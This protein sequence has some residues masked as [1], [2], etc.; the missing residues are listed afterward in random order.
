MP[1]KHQLA[2]LKNKPNKF[3][4]NRVKALGGGP[5]ARALVLRI[6]I[7]SPRKP[8]SAKR[9]AAKVIS[10]KTKKAVFAHVPGLGD[11]GVNK[12]AI[13]M[14]EG[15]GFKDVGGVN[16]SMIRG[17]LGF[18]DVESYGRKKRRSKFGVKRPVDN[19]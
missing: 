8:N 13:V 16:Y 7:V 5:Q 11:P 10:I 4:H 14:I 15:G 1:T 2:R 18:S 19:Q 17:L 6:N 9:R 3:R 12:N